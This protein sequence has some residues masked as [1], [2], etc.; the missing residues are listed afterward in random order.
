ML[1]DTSLVCGHYLLT[2]AEMNQEF[3]DVLYTDRVT[4]IEW[5]ITLF[6][7]IPFNV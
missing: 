2:F 7:T 1:I 5:K 6:V 4:E 3:L